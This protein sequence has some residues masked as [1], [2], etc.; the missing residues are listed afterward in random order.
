V[1]VEHVGR[2]LVVDPVTGE[3]DDLGALDRHPR[4]QAVAVDD[5]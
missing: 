4:R 3:R 5:G 1:V 2:D